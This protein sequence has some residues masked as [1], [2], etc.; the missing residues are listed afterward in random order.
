MASTRAA[1]P[2]ITVC[3]GP[4][5][6]AIET[7]ARC[8]ATAAAT[9][10]SAAK[11]AAIAPPAASDCINRPR[12]AISR[13]ALSRS[14]MPATQAAVY[15]PTEWPI[16][17]SGSTPS[18]RHSSDSAYSTANSAG[19][20]YAVSSSS[21]GAP[22]FANNTSSSGRSRCGASRLATRS[23]AVRYTGAASYSPRVMPAY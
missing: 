4:F 8:G 3:S 15:S 9:I 22:G 20:V 10:D 11:T 17:S 16:T 19:C 21:A 23:R 18:E 13:A 14:R 5:T 7:S 2:E 6:A 1:R 12:T